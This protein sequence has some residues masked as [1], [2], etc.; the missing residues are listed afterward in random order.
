MSENTNTTDGESRAVLAAGMAMAGPVAPE[1]GSR[2]VV[3][4][5]GY[6][7]EDIEKFLASPARAR[8]TITAETPEAFVE[9]YNRFCAEAASLIFACTEH[10]KVTGIIDWHEPKKDPGFAE[11][12]VVYEAPRSDEWKVW[13]EMDGQP[14]SQHDFSV[15]LENNVKDIQEP[16]GAN[17]LEVA[18]QLE[19]KKSVQFS[20]ALRLSDGQR[21]FTFNET[22]DGTTK[23]GQM[24]IP[25]EFTLGIPVFI[26]GELKAVTARLRYRIADGMLKLWYELA[27]ADAVARDAFGEVVEKIRA[28]VETPVLMASPSA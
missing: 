22:V 23:R 9:Y 12:R 19:V 4:P 20:S 28:D 18:Q 3:V 6:K 16:A 7:V 10:F 15:F 14:M 25:E 17:V 2:F 27:Q 5:D 21:E 13:T 24:K 1:S 11:H 8:G 26:S